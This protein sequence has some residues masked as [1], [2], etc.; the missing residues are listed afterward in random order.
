MDGDSL[1]SSQVKKNRVIFV[2]KTAEA[3]LGD[4]GKWNVINYIPP[5]YA[6]GKLLIIQCQFSYQ[7]DLTTWTVDQSLI[8]GHTEPCDP[9]EL[10]TKD[11]A[12]ELMIQHLR[13][14]NYEISNFVESH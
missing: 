1:I 6:L 7:L 12:K 8:K 4:F 11:Q 5:F 14:A 2:A 9:E 13:D 10:P 3:S